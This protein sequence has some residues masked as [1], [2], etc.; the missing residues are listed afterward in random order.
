L[1]RQGEA[2]AVLLPKRTNGIATSR[3]LLWSKRLV[4]MLREGRNRLSGQR[5]PV[6]GRPF[7][8]CAQSVAGQ[9]ANG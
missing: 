9:L 6:F 5:L 2:L 4:L 7:C 3:K 1:Q 8:P